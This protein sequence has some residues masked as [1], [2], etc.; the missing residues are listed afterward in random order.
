MPYSP[1]DSAGKGTN[2]NRNIPR[3]RFFFG[4]LLVALILGIFFVKLWMMSVERQF[5]ENLE[6]RWVDVNADQRL[7]NLLWNHEDRLRQ[8]EHISW[9]VWDHHAPCHEWPTRREIA[10]GK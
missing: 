10:N 2:L 4:C 8:T 6:G 1:E 3:E 5:A 9:A 7:I